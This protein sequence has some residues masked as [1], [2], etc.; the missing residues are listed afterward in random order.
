[1]ILEGQHM[2]RK[3]LR[4]VKTSDGWS[5]LAKACVA[6]AN[7]NGGGTVLVGIEDGEVA[8]PEG[9]SIAEGFEH[10]IQQKLDELTVN[11]NLLA[12]IVEAPNGAEYVSLKVNRSR[13]RINEK[14]KILCSDR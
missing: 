6:F 9:Q 2:E 8:P 10:K 4:S 5:T 14:R 13:C 11:V 7:T 1:M 3:S 12:T